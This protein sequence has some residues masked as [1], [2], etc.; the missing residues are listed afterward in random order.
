LDGE[1]I[2]ILK[3]ALE[4]TYTCTPFRQRRD[5][6]EILSYLWLDKNLMDEDDTGAYSS[7]L[8][9]IAFF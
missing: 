9:I 5:H 6:A 7:M 4:S 3:A 1:D 8:L 2:E